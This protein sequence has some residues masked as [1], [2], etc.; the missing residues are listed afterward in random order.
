[1]KKVQEKQVNNI[2]TVSKPQK[3]LQNTTP[4]YF[5]SSKLD[6]IG[7]GNEGVIV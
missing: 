6:T 3:Y 2:L 1:M 5:L 7:Q 4:T